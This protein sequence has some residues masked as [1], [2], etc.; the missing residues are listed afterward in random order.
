M[1]TITREEWNQKKRNGYTLVRED[2]T[3]CIVT[4]GKSGGT[5][6][7]PVKVA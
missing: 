3:R 6:L 1:R 2:G 7:V 5:A 4:M